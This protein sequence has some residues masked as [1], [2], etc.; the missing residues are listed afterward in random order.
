MTMPGSKF[1]DCADTGFRAGAEQPGT[2]ATSSQVISDANGV[3][4]GIWKCTPGAFTFPGRPNTES[5]LILSGK[6]RSVVVFIV[7]VSKRSACEL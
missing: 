6:V 3:V 2:C 4:S 1:D 5:V 7:C